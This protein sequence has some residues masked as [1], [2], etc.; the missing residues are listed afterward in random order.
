MAFS[1]STA[2]T[3][4]S[5]SEADIRIRQ[6]DIEDD[7]VAP[8]F[9]E[10]LEATMPSFWLFLNPSERGEV[11]VAGWHLN[12]MIQGLL[13]THFDLFPDYLPDYSQSEYSD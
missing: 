6:L 9:G 7:E 12:E 10:I 8:Y 4:C 5:D 2:S 3:V 1:D 11:L 13:V